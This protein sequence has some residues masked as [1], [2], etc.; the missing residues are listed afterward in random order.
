MFSKPVV[1]GLDILKNG[2]AGVLEI[3][4]SDVPCGGNLKAS[5]ERFLGCVVVA[6]AF[7]T[8]AWSDAADCKQP[9]VIVAGIRAASII[10][11][12]YALDALSS[13]CHRR[14]PQSSTTQCG[15]IEI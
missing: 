6:V 12:D 7:G 9:L 1:E 11:V 8:H 2:A 10:V 13:A 4:K 15:V 5:K 14:A 3:G